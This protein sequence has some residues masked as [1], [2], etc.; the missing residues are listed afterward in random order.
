V[1]GTVGL[2]VVKVVTL[3]ARHGNTMERGGQH[4]S[5][6]L[7]VTGCQFHALAALFAGNY[8]SAAV[9]Q[10]GGWTQIVDPGTF[11]EKEVSCNCLESNQHF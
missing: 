3:C 4:A 8:L 2:L 5:L 10:E 6:N 11:G 1:E 9:D 7:T